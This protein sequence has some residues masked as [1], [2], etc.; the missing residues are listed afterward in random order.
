[1]RL[2]CMEVLKKEGGEARD[3]GRGSVDKRR[4]PIMQLMCLGVLEMW[5]DEARHA[6]RGSAH[7][8]GVFF[9]F[10]ALVGCRKEGQRRR[11][12]IACWMW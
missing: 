11:W 9:F 7:T 12:T 5:E 1:M 10:R 2:L 8:K 6:G 4:V 3:G